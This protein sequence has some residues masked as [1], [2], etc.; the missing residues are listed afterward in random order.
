MKR[1]AG[2]ALSRWISE[3]R[4]LCCIWAFVGTLT[5][6]GTLSLPPMIGDEVT[7]FYMLDH[8]VEQLP[9][10][11]FEA[12]IP[13]PWKAHPPEWKEVEVRYYPHAMLWHYALSIPYWLFGRSAW[14]VQCLHGLF[15]LQLLTGVLR[16]LSGDRDD[17][18]TRWLGVAAIASL[19]MTVLFSVAFY[20]DVPATAQV[21][22]AFYY[23]SR[24]RWIPGAIFLALA[25][26]LKEN[27][28]LFVPAYGIGI[29]GM[30]WRRWPQLIRGGLGTALIM[31]A[32]WSGSTMA[33][34]S[35][36]YEYY[37]A[38]TLKVICNRLSAVFAAPAPREATD[39]KSGGK[40]P[41]KAVSSPAKSKSLSLYSNEV[42]ANHPGDLRLPR[43]WIIYG[44]G[45]VPL[46]ILLAL[47][48]SLFPRRHATGGATRERATD[49][50]LLIGSGSYALFTY[51]MLRTSPDARF[52]YPAQVLGVLA[53]VRL[54]GRAPARRYWL[55]CIVMICLVQAGTVLAR[56][57][58]LRHVPTGITEAVT[59]LAEHPPV[60]HRIFM[61]PEGNYRLFPVP[62]N[63]YLDYRL[64]ELW[65]G[66]NDARIA[67]LHQKNIGAIVVKKHL[68]GK[69]DPEMHNLGVYPQS[70]VDDVRKDTR[71]KHVF[72]NDAVIIWHV[73]ARD[74]P[75]AVQ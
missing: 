46:V 22:W 50:L 53:V 64:R 67:L 15:L 24:R 44:G 66:D 41:T 11:N 45:V 54:A 3:H 60:P 10:A 62:H 17:A 63:W 34:H 27:M 6:V 47:L 35:R 33:L 56:T 20:Q 74:K 49:L 19:P 57:W 9:R 37:P 69:I 61:Y 72:E 2:N 55:P 59:H 36:G 25:A 13:D 21:V 12:H 23:L 14:V 48:G 18:A 26:S 28:L 1:L 43:N 71:F 38:R 58:S 5:I 30:F 75:P 39:N 16:L 40:T 7:H 73:P 42:I 32:A 70:F 29:V 52:F 31:G 51:Y 65:Q 8:Q 4:L 68:V